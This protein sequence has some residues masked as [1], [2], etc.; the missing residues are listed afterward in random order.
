MGN[1]KKLQKIQ[2]GT[3]SEEDKNWR[4]IEAKIINGKKVSVIQQKNLKERPSLPYYTET[5][6]VYIVI[7][8]NKELKQMAIY[9]P[10]SHERL[11]DFDWSHNHKDSNYTFEKGELHVHPDINS[12]IRESRPATEKEKR[13]LKQILK[14]FNYDYT[15]IKF[16]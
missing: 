16:D 5:S 3:L 2:T 6:D 15:K 11:K 8:K 1:S 13:Y 4:T 10:I 14:E 7:D 12:E 9:N